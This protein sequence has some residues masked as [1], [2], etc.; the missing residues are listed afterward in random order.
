MRIPRQRRLLGTSLILTALLLMALVSG[1]SGVHAR[2]SG[3]AKLDAVLKAVVASPDGLATRGAMIG[4][5]PRADEDSPV[6]VLVQVQDGGDELASFL[7][8]VGGQITSSHGSIRVVSLPYRSLLALADLPSVKRLE[9][10]Y[11]LMPTLDIARAATGTNAQALQLARP[12]VTGRGVLIGIIDTGVDTTL[13]AFKYA[14]GASRIL[15]FW[16]QT[17]DDVTRF[18]TVRTPEGV[19]KTYSYGREYTNNDF[20]SGTF[21]FGDPGFHGTHVAGIAGGYDP[22]YQGMAPEAAFL[23]VANTFFTSP[24]GEFV[25]ADIW[26]GAGTGSTL[27]AYEYILSRARRTGLPLV[28]NQSQGQLMGPHDGSTLFEQALQASI[29]DATRNLI[30]CISAGNSGDLTGAFEGF[31]HAQANVPA[32]GTASVFLVLQQGGEIENEFLGNSV[33]TWFDGDARLNLTIKSY[34]DETFA[35]LSGTSQEIAFAQ[36]GNF[37]VDA[38]LTMNVAKETPSAGNGDNRFLLTAAGVPGTV[39][40][41]ELAFRNTGSADVVVDLY[42]QRNT[43]SQFVT[44]FTNQGTLGSPGTTP[45]AIT[46]GSYDTRDSW[47]DINGDSQVDSTITLGDLS[48]FSSLGPPRNPALYTGANATKPDIAGPGADVVSQLSSGSAVQTVEQSPQNVVSAG[49]RNYFVT[50]GT[51]MSSPAVAGTVA[52][53]LM[54]NPTL[55]APE[56]KALLFATA[57]QDAFTAAKPLGFGNGKVDAQAAF[58][59]VVSPTPV[60]ERIA[61]VEGGGLEI[62]GRNFAVT[63]QVFVDGVEATDAVWENHMRIFVPSVTVD[64]PNWTILVRNNKAPVG[65]QD[66]AGTFSLGGLAGGSSDTGAGPGAGCFVAT[67][68]YGSYLDPHVAV[69]RG[70]RD[71]WLLSNGPGRALVDLYYHLSPPVARLIARHE[72]LRLGAR[73]ALTPVVYALAYPLPAAAL[74]LLLAGLAGRR[75]LQKG[76]GRGPLAQ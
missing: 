40:F 39:Q 31:K 32:G 72:A 49:G 64:K 43:A 71:R 10:S 30:T 5:A 1:T 73:L 47:V 45:G 36:Q 34:T 62:I 17:L 69:L 33:D 6:R 20:D 50:G 52:L 3:L 16:D 38:A 27:D 67:A 9:A 61:R 51:S 19:D 14:N 28:I 68:A 4:L 12:E 15:F 13:P 2:G 57:R 44:G 35:T 74:V 48:L 22:F 54:D 23:V 25:G 76:A 58:D 8:G 42:L 70:F 7:E 63:S 24:G 26:R 65:A 11:Q 37:V 60:L 66:A 46:V 59:A 75:R 56:V 53:M 21:S 29:D 55:T 41:L 18:P